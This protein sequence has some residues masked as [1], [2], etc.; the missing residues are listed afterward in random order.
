MAYS[1]EKG[2]IA[3][4]TGYQDGKYTYTKLNLNWV[5]AESVT[6]TPEQ[7]IDVDSY[8][9]ANGYLKRTVLDHAPT[10]W[11]ANTTVLY[12]DEVDKFLDLLDEG[13]SLK[14]GKCTK[15]K[16]QLRI[17]YYNE[18]ERGYSEGHAY[19]PV[20]SFSYKLVI[21]DKLVYQPIRFA[22]IEL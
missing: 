6:S 17:R 20:I 22:F 21:N 11:E 7:I 15:K 13:F 18:W 12:Q 1:K 19:I 3:I 5:Q 8:R 4:A 16:R 10:K 14:D 9:N 2:L